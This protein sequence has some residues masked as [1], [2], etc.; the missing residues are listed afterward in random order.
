MKRLFIEGCLL[1]L[2]DG[3]EKTVLVEVSKLVYVEIVYIW[4][5]FLRY[6][7]DGHVL[8]IID[9]KLVSGFFLS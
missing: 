4:Q 7:S 8:A 6:A 1:E 2:L 3:F 9:N 5:L